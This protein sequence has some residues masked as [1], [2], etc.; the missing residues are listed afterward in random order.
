M[1]VNVR[2][3]TSIC[4][5][6]AALAGCSGD[7][8]VRAIPGTSVVFDVSVE[9]GFFDAPF[10]IVHRVREDRSLIVDDFP[11]PTLNTL[12]TALVDELSSSPAGFGTSAA[13]F[14]PLDGPIDPDSLPDIAGSLETGASVFLVNIDPESEELDER[15]PL[16]VH[17]KEAAETYSPTNLLVV[18]PR[19]GVVLRPNTLYSVVVTDGVRDAAGRALGSPLAMEQLKADVAPA[20]PHGAVLLDSY[21]LLW[22]HLERTSFSRRVVRGATVFRTGDPFV[23]MEVLREY[24]QSLPEPDA[25]NLRLIEDY[26]TYC[27]LEGDVEVPL[28]QSGTRPYSAAGGAIRLDAEGRPE[29]VESESIRFSLTI[30]KA[31]MPDSGWPLLFYS[32]G[33]GGSYTQVC[34]RGTFDEQEHTPGRGPALYLADVGIAALSIEAPLVGPRSPTGDTS[35][36]EFYNVVN[37]VALRDNLRQT[38]IDFSSLTRLARNLR[39]PPDLC[40]EAESGDADFSFDDERFLFYGHSTG[41]VA[42]SIVLGL[43]R[44]FAAGLLSGVGA[45]GYYNLVIKEEPLDFSA[46]ISM[47]LQ[48]GSDD[49]PDIYDPVIQ[50]FH[51]FAESAEPLSWARRWALQPP[52]GADPIHVLIIEGVFDGYFPPPMANALALAAGVEPVSPTVEDTLIEALSLVGAE[53]LA[54]PVCNNVS[55]SNGDAS[56]LLVQYTQPEGI[57]GHYVPFELSEPKYQY[58]CFFDSFVRTGEATAF[59]ANSDPFAPCPDL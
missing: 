12:V 18:L 27:V 50:L 10:P 25:T 19:P 47:L 49:E 56:L 36:M 58:R 11:N 23:E 26:E 38:A 9:A 34:S 24:I 3:S 22:D 54:P 13:I 21:R 44:D 39:V 40:V 35:G 42:G 41:A 45:G 1:D 46:L 29:T 55:G 57:S 16:W 51:T 20:G 32:A 53:E 33:Q 5:L 7:D 15:L 6:T 2:F 28:F 52:E 31:P 48:Y 43:E 8:G 59:A 30:P 14:L 4:L 37:P 17:F